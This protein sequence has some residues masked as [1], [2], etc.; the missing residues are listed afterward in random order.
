MVKNLRGLA[1]SAH[2]VAAMQTTRDLIIAAAQRGYARVRYS[3][4]ARDA[5]VSITTVRSVVEHGLRG[6]EAAR[7]VLRVLGVEAEEGGAA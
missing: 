2:C 7:R 1:W 4:V 6:T 3:D 5:D